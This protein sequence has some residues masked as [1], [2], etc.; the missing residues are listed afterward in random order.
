MS[1]RM[2]TSSEKSLPAL[3][4]GNIRIWLLETI[5]PLRGGRL[6][7]VCFRVVQKAHVWFPQGTR[8]IL[9]YMPGYL[10]RIACGG[11]KQSGKG[12]LALGPIGVCLIYPDV[13]D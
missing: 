8:C 4:K 11:G 13:P 9:L 10:S 2:N 1:W 5:F 12:A 3:L 7:G 6:T